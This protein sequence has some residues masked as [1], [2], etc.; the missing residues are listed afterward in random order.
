MNL[1]WLHYNNRFPKSSDV[2]QHLFFAYPSFDLRWKAVSL[3][4]DQNI[5]PPDAYSLRPIIDIS[6]PLY[7][8][9]GNPHLQPTIRKRIS[10]SYFHFFL[11][12]RSVLGFSL[13][14][15]MEKNGTISITELD[16]NR[17]SISKPVNINGA[18][19]YSFNTNYSRQ[20][21]ISNRIWLSL[22]PQLSGNIDQRF[23]SINGFLSKAMYNRGSLHLDL[24]LNYKD[25]I[26]LSQ[27]YK[28]Q[29][30]QSRYE[31]KKNYRDADQATHQLE[32]SVVVRWPKRVVWETQVDYMFNPQVGPG[33][34]PSMVR[35]NGSFYYAF[36]KDEKA[37]LKLSVYDILNQSVNVFRYTME[38]SITDYQGTTLNRYGL[39]SFVYNIRYF[40]GEKPGRRHF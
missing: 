9:Y 25:V 33:I 28:V 19:M 40:G 29:L 24:S 38:G 11:S 3:G 16:S 6:S 12:S 14:M 34:R 21:K 15:S 17:V 1:L 23:V 8:S 31:D 30:S 39:V 22:R 32:S 10:V 4:Y 35:W 26:E 5:S 36:S 27:R 7:K 13:D 18:R 2:N 20:F 37:Q